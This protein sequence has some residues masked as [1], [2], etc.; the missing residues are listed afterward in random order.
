[1]GKGRVCFVVVFWGF[2]E[3]FLGGEGI[4]KSDLPDAT[5][6]GLETIVEK[7]KK[8][9]VATLAGQDTLNRR[10]EV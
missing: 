2:F 7:L 3:S 5:S 10:Q 8:T 1:M 4:G 9:I 6:P